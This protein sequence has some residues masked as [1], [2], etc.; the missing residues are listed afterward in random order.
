MKD[1]IQ[2]LIVNKEQISII[3]S[4]I[5]TTIATITL[6]KSIWESRKEQK[7]LEEAKKPLICFSLKEIDSDLILYVSNKGGSPANGIKIDLISLE[8]NNDSELET[9]ELFKQVFDL[10]PGESV[11]DTIGYSGRNIC[12]DCAAILSLRYSYSYRNKNIKHERNVIQSRGFDY[13]IHTTNNNLR[14]RELEDQLKHIS[15]ASNRMANYFDGNSLASF[16]NLEIVSD[17]SLHD[18][19]ADI[20]NSK[21]NVVKTKRTREETIKKPKSQ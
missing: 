13:S 7:K 11:S 5:T 6:C 10:Y 4:I 17:R 16:D 1:F 8:N 14:I 3:L 21:D 18:D 15:M 20:V 19:L 9:S 2:Y 12:T